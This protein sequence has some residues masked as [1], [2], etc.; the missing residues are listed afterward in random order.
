M[1]QGS[2]EQV[3]FISLSAL[4][5]VT[6]YSWGETIAWRSSCVMWS[7]ISLSLQLR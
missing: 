3:A 4:N 6:K 5:K 7:S 1:N 2:S